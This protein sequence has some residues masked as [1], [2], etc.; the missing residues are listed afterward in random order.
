VQ[1]KD[2][3][4]GLDVVDEVVSG[5]AD[6]GIGNSGLLIDRLAGKPVVVLATIFQHSPAVYIARR[7]SA[8]Q[9]VHDLAGQRV[10]V[11]PAMAELT[12]YLRREGIADD[13]LT[14]VEHS[15]NTRDLID[16][17][18]DAMSAYL[19]YE[20]YFLDQAGVD[21]QIFTPRSV[22]IDFYGDNLFTSESLL[23]ARP[24]LARA[25]RRASLRAGSTPWP[26]PARSPR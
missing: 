14:V 19:S 7:Q 18:V 22:G 26:T 11:E 16:G 25:F 5:R 17:K 12:A 1:L 3:R 21:Y 2:A 23:K 13:R 9:S 20:P 6:F 10:M 24:D 8:A 4:P 15:F